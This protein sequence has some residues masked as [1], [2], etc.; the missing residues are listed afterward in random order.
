VNT[1]GT[2]TR[3]NT[4]ASRVRLLLRQAAELAALTGFAVAQPILDTFGRSP[5]SFIAVDASTRDIVVFAVAIVAV[6]LLACV[7]IEALVAWLVPRA[8]RAVHLAFLA[9]LVA[10]TLVQILKRQTTWPGRSVFLVAVLVAAGATYAYRRFE[11]VRTWLAFAAIAPV[12]FLVLFLVASPTAALLSG[13]NGDAADVTVG[14]PAPVVLVV[15]DEFPLVSLLD[16][17]GQVDPELFPNFAAF[18]R[19]A[20]WYRN[21][22]TV[23][24][25]TIESVPAIFTGQNPDGDEDSPAPSASNYPESIFTLLGATYRLNAHEWLTSMCELPNCRSQPLEGSALRELLGDALDVWREDA[26]PRN[27]QGADEEEGPSSVDAEQ[28]LLS[29]DRPEILGDF[30]S[31]MTAQQ[32]SLDVLHVALPHG[33]WVHLPDGRDYEAPKAR[34]RKTLGIGRW[35][36]EPG[37]GA[38]R[39]RHLLQVQYADRFV[40]DLVARL[41]ELD[42][43]EES[44]VVLVSDHGVSFNPEVANRTIMEGNESDIAWVPFFVKYPG[45]TEGAVDD[46][47]VLT[48]DALP[49]I[50]DA[51]DVEPPWEVDGVV[52]GSRRDDEKW[53]ENSSQ[54]G[55]DV[56]DGRADVDPDAF[57]AVLAAPA[58]GLG[59]G[60]LRV[61]RYG[62]WGDL[63]GEPVADLEVGEPI[64]SS[65]SV[66]VPAGLRELHL[67]R[68]HLPIYV[69]GNLPDLV[70][71]DVLVTVNGAVA[72][73]SRV[74][75]R[76]EARGDFGVLLPPP[77]LHDGENRVT[78]YVVDGAADAPVLH[79]LA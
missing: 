50:A 21:A 43:Y 6:P 49:T 45:E 38:A 69:Q 8:L 11:A 30:L 32:R 17:K 34:S 28:L 52:A 37:A 65:G 63:V 41:R 61:W 1:E 71:R 76:S 35:A 55:L 2:P 66:D 15:F 68:P 46:S 10:I 74:A 60:P 33:D 12:L 57:E 26:W 72:G 48:I 19:D 29:S 13:D 4:D 7:A 14:K 77:L 9:V 31:S 42:R 75:E 25:S 54:V 24:P 78:V 47:N 70:N 36:G 18:T 23:S 64:E 16:G 58:P 27:P 59:R 62:Q 67:D 40:G 79:E 3:E 44:M 73:W 20:T 56:R 22:T 39:L 5:E 53:V 51:L